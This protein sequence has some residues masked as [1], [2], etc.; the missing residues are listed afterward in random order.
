MIWAPDAGAEL[1]ILSRVPQPQHVER[2]RHDLV[3]HLI[4]PDQD[5]AN[6]L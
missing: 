6:M 3:A 2:G 5:A 1:P 4:V